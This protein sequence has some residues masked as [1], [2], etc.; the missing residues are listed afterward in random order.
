METNGAQA[1]D[2]HTAQ[3]HEEASGKR[4]LPA[5]ELPNG[6]SS[7]KSARLQESP[8]P[9][10]PAGT[11]RPRGAK[12]G[13][14]DVL[15]LGTGVSFAIPAMG[16]ILQGDCA[17]CKNAL[18]DP[19]SKDRRCN[20]SVAV[21]V[22]GSGEGEDDRNRDCILIDAGKTMREAI[23]RQFPKEGIRRINSLLLTHDH[24]DATFGLDDLR[25]L[26]KKVHEPQEGGLGIRLVDPPIEVYLQEATFATIKDA[27]KYL[28][29]TTPWLDKVSFSRR[30]RR[31]RSRGEVH[32]STSIH[33]TLSPTYRPSVCSCAT[34]PCWSGS[35][36]PRTTPRCPSRPTTSRCRP[37]PST[38]V[39]VSLGLGLGLVCGFDGWVGF[40][41]VG[42]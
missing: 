30:T 2:G 39:A 38:T 41:W 21:L 8:A 3:G 26:Q 12:A 19:Y 28:V 27:F 29:S 11:P 25:D 40:G 5:E 36:W 15:F 16:H 23:L 14:L 31:R 35:P 1:Q 34:C 9:P 6:G 33:L 24:A 22:N 7:S 17:V 42:G 10:V 32:S 20:V 18:T 37:F 4:S 13:T